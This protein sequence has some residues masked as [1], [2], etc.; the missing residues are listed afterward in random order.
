MKTLRFLYILILLYPALIQGRVN[1]GPLQSD[2]MVLQ[3]N[4]DVKLWGWTQPNRKVS[5]KGSWN[6]KKMNTR[7][8]DMGRFAITLRTGAGNF[9]HQTIGATE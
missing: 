1:M 5:V 9:T 3:Q 8:D 6:G 4:A 7:S 2:G